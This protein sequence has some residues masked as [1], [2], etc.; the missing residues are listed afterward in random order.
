MKV[1]VYK[2]K[3]RYEKWKEEAVKEGIRKLTK[4]NSNILIK[5]IMDMEEG[6]NTAK[7]SKKGG[8]SYARLCN[9]SQRLSQIFR[10]LQERGIKD[11]RKVT[12]KQITR[13]FSDMDKGGI[14]TTKGKTYKSV[15]DYLKV[16]KAFWHW[17]MKVNR[18][19]GRGIPDITED[20]GV[21]T[22]KPKF[23]YISKEDLDKLLPFFTKEEQVMLL[24]MW[25]S[26]IR[27]PT[28]LM[29]LTAGD[30]YEK[31]GEIW[32]NVP[33]EVS[34]TF[35]RTYNL[36]YC[37]ESLQKYIKEKK[38]S[39]EDHLFDFSPPFFNRKLKRAAEQ[40]FGDD[41][42]HP[43]S[44][45]YKNLNLYDF[46]HSGTV[47][48]RLLAKENPDLVSLDAIRHRGG[49]TDFKMLNYY[50]QFLGMDGKIDKQ[51]MLIRKDRHIL[52]KKLEALL[53]SLDK[54]K[55]ISLKELNKINNLGE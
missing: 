43:K 20:I 44:D 14:K 52:E 42:P 50:T 40:L 24:F 8:R 37:G 31:E 48:L 10:M 16:F 51:G 46:R 3:T 54:R 38:L 6:S 45:P 17:W 41:K 34:K 18:K 12:E 53:R 32:V 5:Y 29:S 30:I 19:K 1:D 2:F 22:N 25:D 47:H 15:E 39:P 26:I 28:E 11:I 49:W 9:L 7:V 4:S 33:D 21:D 55:L 13:F 23:V 27:A 35:G 36:L